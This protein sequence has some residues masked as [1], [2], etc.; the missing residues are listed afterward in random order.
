MV[1]EQRRPPRPVVTVGT[2]RC[3]GLIPTKP[4]TGTRGRYY[5]CTSYSI[6]STLVSIHIGSIFR[7]PGTAHLF[8]RV[9]LTND[10]P[11]LS[12]AITAC[13]LPTSGRR[14]CLAFAR[15][16]VPNIYFHVF[17]KKVPKI[18]LFAIEIPS[19]MVTSSHYSCVFRMNERL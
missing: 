12:A 18:T 4:N 10:C 7:R 2:G 15:T 11:P 8:G 9:P 3:T 16:P 6:A 13:H 17:L 14:L 5:H 19:A 1:V